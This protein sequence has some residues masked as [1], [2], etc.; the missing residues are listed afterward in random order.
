MQMTSFFLE[1]IATNNLSAAKLVF[2]S[3]AYYTV[4]Y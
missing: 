1:I 3:P 2:S 4:Y